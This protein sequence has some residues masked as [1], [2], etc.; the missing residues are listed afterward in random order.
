MG[1]YNKSQRHATW[2]GGLPLATSRGEDREG[3]EWIGKI[4][5]HKE[6]DILGEDTCFFPFRPDTLV[7]GRVS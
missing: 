7:M 4:T 5:K 3:R 1:L 2:V 6:N